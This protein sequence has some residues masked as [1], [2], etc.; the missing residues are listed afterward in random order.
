MTLHTTQSIPDTKNKVER[1]QAA[2]FT[3]DYKFFE[4]V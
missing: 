1:L 3:M 2:G 4:E